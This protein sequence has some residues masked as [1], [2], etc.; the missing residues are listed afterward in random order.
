MSPTIANTDPRATLAAV[1]NI[2][3]AGTVEFRFGRL[4]FCSHE[5]L[6]VGPSGQLVLAAIWDGLDFAERAQDVKRGTK[7]EDIA[8]DIC[9]RYGRKAA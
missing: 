2:L 3:P 9:A 8:A 5:A 7:A 6:F 4:W 1:A